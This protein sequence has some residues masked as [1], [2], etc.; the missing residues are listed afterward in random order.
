MEEAKSSKNGNH[1]P[2]K[3]AR[4]VYE[5]GKTVR[6]T[7]S[8]NYKHNRNDKSVKDVGRSSPSGNSSKKNKQ[9]DV[10]SEKPGDNKSCKVNSC[11]PGTKDAVSNLQDRSHGKAKK[12]P[13]LPAAVENLKQVKAQQ[14]GENFP[15]S[16]VSGNG[17]SME[18]SAVSQRGKS[19][20]EYPPGT[21]LLKTHTDQT[22][23][24]GK[25]VSDQRTVEH[26]SDDF[27]EYY[28]TLNPLFS[29]SEIITALKRAP[30]C[31][32]LACLF[33]YIQ[34]I[35]QYIYKERSVNLDLLLLR[36]ARHNLSFLHCKQWSIYLFRAMFWLARQSW[37]TLRSEITLKQNLSNITV[38]A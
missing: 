15:S 29:C 12:V 37:A 35:F 17:V 24:P 18:T 38:L 22:G 33:S 26:K 25:T 32:C 7:I 30:K 9:N 1:D 10:C 31:F 36:S 20:L 2:R 14:V 27:S 4:V 21:L 11:S 28:T 23:D 19:A 8:Q 3:S 13:N 34:Q 16:P 6:V 5:E